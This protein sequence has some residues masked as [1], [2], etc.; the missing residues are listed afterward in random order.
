MNTKP[1]Y[2]NYEICGIIQYKN[3]SF[4][5]FIAQRVFIYL[6]LFYIFTMKTFV[7]L[8]FSKS[9]PTELIFTGKVQ[10]VLSQTE[11]TT[12]CQIRRK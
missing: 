1:F 2:W 4:I 6:F 5:L 11:F 8:Q 9:S 7:N 12:F 10:N 3:I